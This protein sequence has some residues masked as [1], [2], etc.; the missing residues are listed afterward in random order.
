MD[1]EGVM[2]R[3]QKGIPTDDATGAGGGG[4]GSGAG[5]GGGEGGAGG[6]GG[7]AGAGGGGVTG[8]TM[9][10]APPV[11]ARSTYTCMKQVRYI[12]IAFEVRFKHM[13]VLMI[14]LAKAQQC[15]PTPLKIKAQMK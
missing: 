13:L 10:V 5:T 15:Y 12:C 8:S 6:G 9:G 4:G 14:S 3:M 2:E 1:G 11:P 7:G